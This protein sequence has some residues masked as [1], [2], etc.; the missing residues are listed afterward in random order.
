[1][2]SAGVEGG[3]SGEDED[4]CVVGGDEEEPEG[5]LFP[6]VTRILHF[7]TDQKSPLA[8]S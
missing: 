5:G 2:D 1:M 8:S 4:G 3:I 6:H 7:A